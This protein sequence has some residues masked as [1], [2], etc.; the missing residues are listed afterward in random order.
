[1]TFNILFKVNTKNNYIC[2]Y[3]IM[4]TLKKKTIQINPNFF[5][6]NKTKKNKKGKKKARRN[7]ISS[8]LRPNNVKK[9]LLERIK[10]YQIKQKINGE[11]PDPQTKSLN[12]WQDSFTKS[13]ELLDNVIEKNKEKKKKKKK[14]ELAQ[15]QQQQQQQQQPQQQP[16]LQQQPQPQLQQ[17]QQQPKQQQQPIININT[18]SFDKESSNHSGFV[19]TSRPIQLQLQEHSITQD[20][21]PVSSLKSAPP[22]GIL[23]KGTK[24]TYSQYKKSLKNK[25]KPSLIIENNHQEDNEKNLDTIKRQAKLKELKEK[26]HKMHHINISRDVKKNDNPDKR[27]VHQFKKKYT[28][29]KHKNKVGVLIKSRKKRKTL[30]KETIILKKRPI[31]DVKQ[32]LFNHNLIKKGSCAP[33]KVM[34]NIYESAFLTGDVFNKN[35]ENLIHNYLNN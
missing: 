28:L 34:R 13:M 24:P 19:P 25:S 14:K 27:Y 11:L 10:K 1:M 7:L 21:I 33:E 18:E 35:P 30:K 16:Q 6:L 2:I 26:V 22:W 5:S 17:Q 9:Q 15:N 20:R 29:G 8:S 23:K 31:I 32:Y 4:S 3:T 12:K